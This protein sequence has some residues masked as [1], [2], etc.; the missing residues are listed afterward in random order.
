RIYIA[1]LERAGAELI[2]ARA[3]LRDRNTVELIGQNRTVTAETILIATG[4]W[5]Y[6]PGNVPGAE[7][8]ITSNDAFHLDRLPERIVIVGGGYIAVEFAGIFNGLGV[9]TTLVY[10]R[11]Q[12]LDRKSTRLNSSH[13]KISYAVF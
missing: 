2:Q 12:I 7:H 8:A 13:V 11:D 3:I 1:N 5:P 4:S 10:R 9:E 6:V